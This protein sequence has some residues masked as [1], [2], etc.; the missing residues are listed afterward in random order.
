MGSHCSRKTSRKVREPSLPWTWVLLEQDPTPN[1]VEKHITELKKFD[2]RCLSDIIGIW[3]MA[4]RDRHI[5]SQNIRNMVD[6]ESLVEL[7]RQRYLRWAGH[8]AS[9]ATKN[10]WSTSP[11]GEY[12]IL[13]ARWR[14]THLKKTFAPA[15]HSALSDRHL[16]LLDWAH[17]PQDRAQRRRRVVYGLQGETTAA[18]CSIQSDANQK[19]F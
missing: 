17:R 3:R 13:L 9:A 4:K 5:R 1:R 14:G 6:F 18:C 15:V 8:I 12:L 2:I 11:L 19:K 16:S 10:W 7:L